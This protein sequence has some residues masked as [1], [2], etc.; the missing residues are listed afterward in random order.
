MAERVE[1]TGPLEGKHILVDLDRLRMRVLMDMESDRVT[2]LVRA[3]SAL[4]VGGNI[5]DIGDLS[6]PEFGVVLNAVREVL[7]PKK[8]S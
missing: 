3:V 1:L 6:P 5:G 8:A 7:L 4:V 2:N